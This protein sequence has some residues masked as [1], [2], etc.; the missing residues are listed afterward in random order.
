MKRKTPHFA[1]L[2]AAFA[3]L[4][5]GF[6]VFSACRPQIKTQALVPA[7]AYEA[8][9][10]RRIAVL[11]I[12]G[13][14]GESLTAQVEA[15]LVGIRVNGQPYFQVIERNELERIAAEQKLSLSGMVDE[16]SAAAVGSLIG[17]QGMVWGVT[18]GGKEEMRHFTEDRTNCAQRDKDGKCVRWEQKKVSCRERQVSYEFTFK[19]VEVETGRIAGSET[20]SAQASSRWCEGERGGLETRQALSDKARSQ[21]LSQF[22]LMMAPYT[23]ELSIELLDRDDSKMSGDVKDR[24]DEGVKWLKE[25]R[26]DRAQPLFQAAYASHKE[27]YALPYLLGVCAELSGDLDQAQAYYQQADSATRRPVAAVNAALSRIRQKISDR[28]KLSGVAP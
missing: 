9:R 5:L 8:S 26:P 6:F 21:V 22:R 20:L 24:I 12:S 2:A 13:P 19:V 18:N 15:L 10:L 25:S 3:V 4:A 23:V 17:A 28:A 1:P 14:D 27:G 16:K 7:K 11:P